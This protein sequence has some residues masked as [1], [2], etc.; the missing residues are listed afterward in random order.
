[1]L[2]Q[3]FAIVRYPALTWSESQMWDV[4]NDCVIMHNMIIENE[5]NAPVVD[6]MPFDHQGPLAELL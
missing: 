1:M 6:D 4:M 2:Q 5:R 3:R